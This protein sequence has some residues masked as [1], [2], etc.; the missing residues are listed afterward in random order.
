MP[1]PQWLPQIITVSPWTADTFAELAEVYSRTI[2]TADLRINGCRVWYYREVE[3][4]QEVMFWHLT[5]REDKETGERL[6]DLQRCSKLSWV[7]AIIMNAHQ[8]EVTAWDYIESDG[9]T[10]TYLWLRDEECLVVLR[11]YPDGARRL[12]TAYHV[13]N[14][15]R[16]S[17]ESKYQKRV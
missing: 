2:A 15:T 6:P 14:G 8:P 13:D 4:G 1:T 12:V 16:R 10:N 5:H 9:N 17:L 3:D 7:A 11:K